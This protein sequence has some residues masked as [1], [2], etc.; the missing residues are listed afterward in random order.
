EKMGDLPTLPPDETASAEERRLWKVLNVR[1]YLGKPNTV[2]T[3]S[4]SSQSEATR[5][6]LNYVMKW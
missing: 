4:L 1:L 2:E 3:F 6:G 5:D